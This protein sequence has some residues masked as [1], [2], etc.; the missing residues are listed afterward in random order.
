M[1]PLILGLR[2]QDILD[3]LINSYIL[4]RLYV[5][6][7]GTNVIRMVLAICMLWLLKRLAISI[8]LIVTSWVIQG[9]IAVAALIIIIVFRNEIA[10]VFQVRSL[11]LFFWGVPQRRIQTPV[12]VITESVEELARRKLGALI[13]LPMKKSLEE[14]IHGGVLWQGTLSQEM[15]LSIFWH[16]SPVHDGAIVIQGNQVMKVGTILPLSKNKELPSHFG[17]RHRAAAGLTEQTDALVIVVSEERGEITVFKDQSI[18]NI[19]R[20]QEL[21]EVLQEYAGTVPDKSGARHQT[22]ELAVAALG[23]LV[24]ISGIWF[25]FARGLETLATVEVPVEFVNRDQEMKIFSASASSVKLQISGSGSLIRSVTPDQLNVRLDLANAVPGQNEVPISREGIILPPG[26]SLKQV[27]PE[28]L[29]VNLDVP[30]QKK[31]HIQPNWTGKLSE[32]LIMKEASIVPETVEVIGGRLSLENIKTIY[33]E[34]IPLNEISSDGKIKVGI[35]LLPSSLELA[36]QS[37]KKDIE[38][39]F[40]VVPRLPPPDAE[41]E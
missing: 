13:V 8:G 1:E 41:N 39:T 6:F 31:L 33:T 34:A 38:V 36:D 9:I 23:C 2:W 17:T 10:G 25:S 18:I 27:E 4:F 7:R 37:Q 28:T 11:R 21:S 14:F 24:F 32:Y 26:I 19:E 5:L 22:I 35:M 3:I 29:V 30:E 15:L 16:G 12:N 40:N 20:V